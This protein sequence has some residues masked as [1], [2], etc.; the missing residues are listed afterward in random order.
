[1]ENQFCIVSL[2]DIHF[3][4]GSPGALGKSRV[5]LGE[6]LIAVVQFSHLDAILITETMQFFPEGRKM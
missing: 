5:C 4:L 1:M 3:R 2:I 6:R